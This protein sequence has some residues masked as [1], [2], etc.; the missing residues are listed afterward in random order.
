M[1]MV[2]DNKYSSL[3]KQSDRSATIIIRE[4]TISILEQKRQMENWNKTVS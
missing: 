1:G 3:K 2:L 4:Y